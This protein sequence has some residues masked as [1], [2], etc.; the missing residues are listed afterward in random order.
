MNPF[1]LLAFIS[2][3]LVPSTITFAE[4]YSPSCE[5]AL[6]KIDTARKALIPF[7]RTMEMARARDSG[8]NG[9]AMACMGESRFGV[10]KPIRCHKS[11]WQVPTQT[12]DDLAAV[13]QYR[14]ERQAFDEL[15][16]QAKQICLFE[17]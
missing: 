8:A 13:D 4:P 14:Q 11:Q 2:L 15:F 9:K 7:R 5:I 17:P 6:E 10:D 16:H 3:V 12:K 1:Y